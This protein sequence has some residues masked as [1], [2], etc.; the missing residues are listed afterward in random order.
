MR[1]TFSLP[2]LC[3]F[4]HFVFSIHLCSVWQKIMVLVIGRE[5]VF[6][7]FSLFVSHTLYR[8]SFWVPDFIFPFLF[9]QHFLIHLVFLLSLC[10]LFFRSLSLFVFFPSVLM[11][12]LFFF[13][14]EDGIH[15]RVRIVIVWINRV[16]V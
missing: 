12:L 4:L 1:H 5:V 2:L 9:W 10:F 3:Y 8:T 14:P 13:F 6:A 11:P 7:F 16:C 15:W